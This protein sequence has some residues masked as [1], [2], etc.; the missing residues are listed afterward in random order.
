MMPEALMYDAKERHRDF[1][2]II[3]HANQFYGRTGSSAR[4]T[5]GEF[6]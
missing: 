3:A 1:G 6:F 2:H 5:P 4:I